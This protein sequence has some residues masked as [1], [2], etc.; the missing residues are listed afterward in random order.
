MNF[1]T[2]NNSIPYYQIVPVHPVVPTKG[3][4]EQKE[5]KRQEQKQDSFAKIL[6]RTQNRSK[7]K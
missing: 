4:L 6:K 1:Y 5:Q 2:I 3:N 7:G